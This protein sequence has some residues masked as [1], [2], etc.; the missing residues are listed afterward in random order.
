[1][2]KRILSPRER[3]R[4]GESSRMRSAQTRGTRTTVIAPEIM[5]R[6]G[7]LRFASTLGPKILRPL[8]NTGRR[9]PSRSAA[10]SS[11]DS[12]NSGLLATGRSCNLPHS[13]LRRR[14]SFGPS[15]GIGRVRGLA[16]H[17]S[18]MPSDSA[19]VKQ[20][21]STSSSICAQAR[22]ADQKLA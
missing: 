1:M 16:K 20:R 13:H 6:P 18:T 17:Q 7:K 5:C 21:V 14:S 3:L 9:R 19:I 22:R 11:D 8:P 2:V 4:S 12:Q 15:T 10:A